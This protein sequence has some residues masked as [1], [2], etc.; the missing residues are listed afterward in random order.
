MAG[1][2]SLETPEWAASLSAPLRVQVEETERSARSRPLCP[3]APSMAGLAEL[4]PKGTEKR[5]A[6]FDVTHSSPEGAG[7]QK[8]WD[9]GI[10]TF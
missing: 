4:S 9:I 5:R 8:S 3:E 2:A 6:L 7:P 10:R 1:L